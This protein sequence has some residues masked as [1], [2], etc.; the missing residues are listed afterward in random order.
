MRQPP[1]PALFPYTTL[2][3]SRLDARAKSTG[4]QQFAIDV[5][6]PEMMTAV[7]MRPPRFGARASAFDA[8]K[9]KA[10]AGAVDVVQIRRGVAGVGRA[11]W[12]AEKG[13]DGL[14]G[15]GGGW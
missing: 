15:R 1:T 3:R 13:G 10:V 4:Q 5:M 9:A 12:S 8:S 2:F 6:L 14:G 7:V 11:V